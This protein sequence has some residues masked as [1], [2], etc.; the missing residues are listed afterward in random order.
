MSLDAKGLEAAAKALE[1]SSGD[2]EECCPEIGGCGGTHTDC[3]Y[4]SR[5]ADTIRAYSAAVLPPDESEAAKAVAAGRA[6]ATPPDTDLLTEL[7]K[8][9]EIH[10]N[11]IRP[12]KKHDPEN[13]D[14][15]DCPCLTCKRV[16][17]VEAVVL[18]EGRAAATPDPPDM[19]NMC[20]GESP[21][22]KPGI[23]PAASPDERLREAGEQ[24]AN[25]VTL[26][27]GYDG[28]GY[29]A[30]PNQGEHPDYYAA[31]KLFDRIMRDEKTGAAVVL[32][33]WRAA[34]AAADREAPDEET[35]R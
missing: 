16:A 13:Q 33:Q 24:L 28:P 23:T 11:T 19:T 31:A 8:L 27:G 29:L 10:H 4:R 35:K 18:A 26:L 34:L 1:K 6:A 3:W 21:D 15:R 20:E 32:A 30:A 5:A 17:C 9:T 25:L 7:V 22:H 14:W 2:S 12:S